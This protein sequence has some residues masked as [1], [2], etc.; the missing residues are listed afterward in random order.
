[1]R[2]PYFSLVPSARSRKEEQNQWK[3]RKSLLMSYKLISSLTTS[4]EFFGGGNLIYVYFCALPDW[5]RI[6][7]ALWGVIK[8]RICREKTTFMVGLKQLAIS[9]CHGT[10]VKVHQSE[11]SCIAA[12]AGCYKKGIHP[13]ISINLPDNTKQ[14]MDYFQKPIEINSVRLMRPYYNAPFKAGRGNRDPGKIDACA[15]TNK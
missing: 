3:E 8:W 1:M 14:K 4:T 10:A 13:A 15:R 9:H 2:A 6:F 11:L 7:Y 5:N 12:A